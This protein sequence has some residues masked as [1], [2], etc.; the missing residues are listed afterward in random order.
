MEEIGR[1]TALGLV[2][3]DPVGAFLML[4]AIG[5]GARRRS[6]T[7]LVGGYLVTIIVFGAAAS[8][9]VR[10]G[11]TALDLGRYLPSA[12]VLSWLEIG[13]GVLVIVAA[14]YVARRSRRPQAPESARQ[15]RMSVPALA[16]AG[17]LLALSL[18]ID[19]G[20]V[21]VVGY[22]ATLPVG[23]VVPLILYWG[24]LSQIAMMALYAGALLDSSGRAVRWLHSAF[25]KGRLWLRHHGAWLV[26][27]LGL[28]IVVDGVH[29]L[30]VLPHP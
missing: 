29:R 17:A 27:L 13:A 28:A 16:G 10:L 7:A 15:V 22:A 21:L 24:V 11:L 5:A 19:P 20:F 2:G 9:L 23:A 8:L 18:A 3:F 6:L 1:V 26:L 4:G 30:V 25:D 14:A 12:R